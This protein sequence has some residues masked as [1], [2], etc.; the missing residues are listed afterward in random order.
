MGPRR[1]ELRLL[2]PQ[3]NRMPGYPIAPDNSSHQEGDINRFS[4][5][6]VIEGIDGAGKGTQVSLLAEYLREKLRSR[7]VE[8]GEPTDKAIG[9]LIR[10]ALKSS[11][12]EGILLSLLFSADRQQH[13]SELIEPTLEKGASVVSERYV[14]STLAYQWSEKIPLEWLCELNRYVTPPDLVI[15]LDIAPEDA[16]ERIRMR[17]EFGHKDTRSEFG[18]KEAR[19]C[20]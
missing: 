16:V 19:M 6:L 9:Q 15:F 20:S 18:H 11:H 17:S 3:G 7:V 1:F 13:V 14:Y 8:T 12:P 2:P 10:E 4:F 5:F